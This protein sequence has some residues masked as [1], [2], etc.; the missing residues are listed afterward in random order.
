MFNIG[1]TKEITIENLARL[2]WKL[3]RGDEE[4]KIKFIPYATFGKYEDVMRRI[5]D[6]TKI[7]TML[8]FEPKWHIEEGLTKTIQWQ[9]ER[10]KLLNMPTPADGFCFKG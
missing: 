5:P 6:I 7:N 10:R 2:I 3:I 4:P 9:L 1:Y 8:G